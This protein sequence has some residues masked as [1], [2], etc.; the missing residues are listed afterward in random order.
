MVTQVAQSLPTV[1]IPRESSYLGTLVDDL[2]TKDLREPY[3]M[4]TSRSEWRLLLRADN[5]DQRL[6]PM[7]RELGLVDDQRWEQ[8]ERKQVGGVWMLLC[9][10]L[11][12]MPSNLLF[13]WHCPLHHSPPRTPPLSQARIQAET[14]RLAAVRV[15]PHHPLALDAAACSGQNVP[16]LASLE[17]LLRRPHV[18]YPLLMQHGLGACQLPMDAADTADTADEDGG[19]GPASQPAGDA[20][21]AGTGRGGVGHEGGTGEDGAVRAAGVDGVLV[22]AGAVAAAAELHEPLSVAEYEAVEIDI[23]Y[24]GFIRRQAKQMQQVCTT[25]CA[26]DVCASAVVAQLTGMCFSTCGTWGV[27]VYC[28]TCRHRVN[29][30]CHLVYPIIAFFACFPLTLPVAQMTAKQSKR[31]PD[32]VDYAS[33]ATL[34]LE[35]REKLGRIRPTTIGQASRIGGVN[36]TDIANLLVHLEVCDNSAHTCV[37]RCVLRCRVAGCTCCRCRVL[38]YFFVSCP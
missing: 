26:V 23:K 4:L 2:V 28:G 31:I 3:R 30:H 16:G 36:P 21:E 33:I 32:D 29:Q 10:V 25:W 11:R 17:E 15:Q 6:T 8:Y 19:A 12:W 35:A 34:S 20:Q 7:G 14:R 1:V 22:G 5:A 27:F 13:T 38:V 37:L 18:H 9:G 24:S